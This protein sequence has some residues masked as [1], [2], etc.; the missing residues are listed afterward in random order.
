MASRVYQYGLPLGPTKDSSQLV[1]RQMRLAEDYHRDLIWYAW[2]KRAVERDVLCAL[3]MHGAVEQ[4]RRLAGEVKALDA[5]IKMKRGASRR[6][7]ETAEDREALKAARVALKEARERRKACWAEAGPTLKAAL[8]DIHKRWLRLR[9]ACR[10]AYSQRGQGLRHGTYIAVEEAVAQACSPKPCPLWDAEGEP[11]D[12]KMPPRAGEG[13]IGVQIQ[14]AATVDEVCGGWR[15]GEPVPSTHAQLRIRSVSPLAW[16]SPARAERRRHSRTMLRMRVG[17]GPRR[18]PIW[19]E[20]PLIM[21]RPLPEG[22]LITGAMVSR[23]RSGPRDRWSVEITVRLP[24]GA[25]REAGGRGAIG[26]DIGWRQLDGEVRVCCWRAEGGGSGELRLT[27]AA[28]G[29]SRPPHGRPT[30]RRSLGLLPALRKPDELRGLRDE[31]LDKLRPAFC[32]AL[33]SKGEFPE[34]FRRLTG[35]RT[36]PTPS[37]AQ[38]L[39]RIAKWK[40]P[41][42]FA[43]L[44]LLWRAR[45]SEPSVEAYELLKRWY[46]RDRHLWAWEADLRKKGLRRRREVYRRFAVDLARRY[47]VL[48]LEGEDATGKSK[49]SSLD[50]DLEPQDGSRPLDL[51]QFARHEPTEGE[52]ENATARRNRVRAALSELRGALMQAF[53]ARGGRVLLVPHKGTTE[54]HADCGSEETIGP[55]ELEHTCS[56]CGGRYDRDE[57]A[58]INIVRAGV[59]LLQKGAAEGP[60]EEKESRWAR[61]RRALREQAAAGQGAQL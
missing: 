26:I 53:V 14:K 42:R 52:P 51:R 28:E 5:A 45:G 46:H 36:L 37:T 2:A 31:L 50:P 23:R 17:T 34:P 24:A 32:R 27:S 22:A 12:P 11:N 13:H 4:V 8:K 25:W 3:G 7:S 19:A 20:W 33:A 55:Y 15:G 18:A 60:P 1:E 29:K 16:Q 54:V 57:N 58:G 9:C 35:K 59:V 40:S 38:A 49:K 39:A 56:K 6:R 61:V 43:G 47:G 10:A 30:L 44:F 48:V 41:R 21:H